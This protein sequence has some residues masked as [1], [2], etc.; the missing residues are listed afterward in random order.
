MVACAP[1]LELGLHFFC[2]ALAHVGLGPGAVEN[3]LNKK[4]NGVARRH[5]EY[6]IYIH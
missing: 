5:V 1:V 4:V 6:D 2:A 3:N